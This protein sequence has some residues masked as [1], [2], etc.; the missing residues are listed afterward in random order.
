MG[1][2]SYGLKSFIRRPRLALGAII[3]IM[4]GLSIFTAA[5]MSSDYLTIALV[6]KQLDSLPVDMR[7]DIWG[8]EGEERIEFLRNYKDYSNLLSNIQEIERVYPYAMA[9]LPTN[10]TFGNK[11]TADLEEYWGEISTMIIEENII[12]VNG[13]NLLDGSLSLSAVSYTHL[14][15][16][17]TERV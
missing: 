2:A 4:L 8:Y 17:T 10:I 6:K 5:F 12:E 15:L 14:T 9:Y 1:L 3:G 11:S 13:F 7:V 16:P